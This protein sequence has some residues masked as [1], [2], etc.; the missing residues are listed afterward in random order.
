MYIHDENGTRIKKEYKRGP[1]KNYT[2][3][4][5]MAAVKMLLEDHFSVIEVSRRLRIPCKNIKRWSQYGVERKKGGG[6]KR[7]SPETERRVARKLKELYKEG[8]E[9][10]YVK[11]QNIA[12][13]LSDD[14]T[15]K[16][17][18]GWVVKFVER[19]NLRNYYT[20]V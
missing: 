9:V 11:V 12:I 13:N 3:E 14:P 20:F 7:F 17:S 10:E 6:R 2:V 4:E 19:Q 18:R 1:Y 8:S 5:K 15:F 16:A